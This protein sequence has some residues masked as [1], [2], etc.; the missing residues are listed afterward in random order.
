MNTITIMLISSF[1]LLTIAS[2]SPKYPHRPEPWNQYSEK[3]GQQ[4]RCPSYSQCY[5][6]Y[7]GLYYL[8]VTDGNYTW[9]MLL[10]LREDSSESW[11]GND[12]A[13]D[14]V[15]QSTDAFY[16]PYSSANGKWTCDSTENGKV[17]ITNY[18]FMFPSVK[19]P[20]SNFVYNNKFH[21][22]L[23]NLRQI[24]GT[25]QYRAYNL[26]TTHLDET[27][28]NSNKYLHLDRDQ[29]GDAIYS[30]ISGYQIDRFC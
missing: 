30:T 4:Q 23:N 25:F 1:C 27:A 15:L 18:G 9:Y 20:K 16:Q 2:A 3:Q 8:T 28:H 6:K 11:T 19:Q 12:Q 17:Q 22:N 24:K 10:T 14:E 5:S 21:L 29:V 26:N 13:G 7:A